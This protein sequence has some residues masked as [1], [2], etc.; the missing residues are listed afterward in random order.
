MKINGNEILAR[1]GIKTSRTDSVPVRI[2]EENVS[3]YP[4]LAERDI[5][6][7]LFNM[8]FSIVRAHSAGKKVILCGNGGS[9]ADAQ[10]IAG[11]LA[12]SFEK[13]RPVKAA[14]RK[15]LMKFTEGRVIA[16]CLE[17]GIACVVLGLNHSLTSAVAN[18]FSRPDM[19]YAQE[20]YA[21]A[22]SGDV[23]VGIST[24]GNASNVVYACVTARALGLDTFGLT[25]ERGGKLAK[26][27]ACCLK[28]PGTETRLIQEQQ[29]SVYHV[30]CLMVESRFWKKGKSI[31]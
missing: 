21:V 8:Y 5:A 3:L 24:S 1:F 26:R 18:D 2:F 13:E 19:E 16:D 4:V 22:N 10:H 17:Q 6:V 30:L 27:A 15:R 31:G 28:V 25:G 12:K 20:L 14:E 29:Q 9:M 11:E 7:P 23:F